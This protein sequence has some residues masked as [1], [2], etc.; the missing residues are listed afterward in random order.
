MIDHY[1][2]KI[3]ITDNKDVNLIMLKNQDLIKVFQSK[4]KERIKINI[5]VNVSILNNS[6]KDIVQY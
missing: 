2:L 6:S 1:R 3:G 4:G 5:L